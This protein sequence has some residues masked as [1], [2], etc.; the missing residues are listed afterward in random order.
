MSVQCGGTLGSLFKLAALSGAAAALRL[1]ISKGEP[2]NAIDVHGRTPLLLAASRGHIEACRLLLEAGADATLR[3]NNG[4]DAL[5]LAAAIGTAPLVALLEEHLV[6]RHGPEDELVNSLPVTDEADGEDDLDRGA[7]WVEEEDGPLP[8]GDDSYVQIGSNAQRAMSGH[9]PIDTT[10]A[11]WEDVDIQLPEASRRGQRRGFLDDERKTLLLNM[12]LTGLAT[13]RLTQSAVAEVASSSDEDQTRD[14]TSCLSFALSDLGVIVEDDLIGG[15]ARFVDTGRADNDLAEEALVYIVDLSTFRNDPGRYYQR[16]ALGTDL[17]SAAE[18]ITLAKEMESGRT[19]AV[20]AISCSRLALNEVLRCAMQAVEGRI[21]ASALIESDNSEEGELEAGGLS[22]LD[23]PGD[24]DILDDPLLGPVATASGALAVEFA[25]RVQDLQELLAG[26]VQ[27]QP[28]VAADLLQS[29]RPKI[30]F[31]EAV[32]SELRARTPRAEELHGL[33]SALSAVREARN[34]MTVANLRLVM[35][36]AKKYTN[37]GLQVLDLVQEGNI[38]LMKAVEKYDYHR[39]FRFSTYAT[40]WIRQAIT[41]AIADQARTIRVPVHMIEAINKLNRISR[42]MLVESGR[43]PTLSELAAHMEMPEEKVAKVLK[44]VGEP[45]WM[46]TPIDD[47]DGSNL[48]DFIEDTSLESPIDSA[49]AES[50]RATTHS[51]LAGL[52]P[53]EA[54]VIRMRFGIDM[55]TDHTLEEVGKQFDVTRERIRQIE[56]KALRKLR[57]PSRSEQ[58]RSFLED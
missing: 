48:G 19:D 46:D 32:C 52:T 50:L 56:A 26:D 8:A 57:H 30:A 3:D 20:R 51:V 45:I 44:V 41:R 58:L 33:S 24:E 9:V 31:L 54:K 7:S 42:Q 49:T 53:R 21:S 29:M 35:S 36:I 34:R 2:V 40:W 6:R 39:G 23:M 43:E 55:T 37:R 12:L 11:D 27:L 25:S 18:E 16:D 38:G 13:G 47:I 28:T 10:A 5:S 22:T 15:E 14:F 4:N 17:L 1:Q